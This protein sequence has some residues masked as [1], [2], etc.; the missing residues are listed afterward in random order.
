MS[1]FEKRG[2]KDDRVILEKHVR[3]RYRIIIMNEKHSITD[4]YTGTKNSSTQQ[5]LSAVTN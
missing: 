3:G 5:E 4:V 1:K 2:F